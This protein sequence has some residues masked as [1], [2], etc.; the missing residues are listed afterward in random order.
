MIQ[1]AIDR[2]PQWM[3]IWSAGIKWMGQAQAAAFTGST[4]AA[5]PRATSG[6]PGFS[7]VAIEPRGHLGRRRTG[8]L[9]P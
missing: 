6:L 1:S 8:W 4:S 9:R 5:A 3:G 7:A 2:L